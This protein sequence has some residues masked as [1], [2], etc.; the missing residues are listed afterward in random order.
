LT[1]NPGPPRRIKWAIA[2]ASVILDTLNYGI[3][4]YGLDQIY[5]YFKRELPRFDP[6]QTLFLVGLIQDDYFTVSDDRLVLHTAHIHPEAL[7]DYFLRTPER[8]Y[9]Y[10]FLRGRLGEPVYRSL[11]RESPDA[12]MT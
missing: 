1:E 11:M 10:Y 12:Q 8:F 6:R 4:G 5:L 3:G 7:N 2:L 9:L